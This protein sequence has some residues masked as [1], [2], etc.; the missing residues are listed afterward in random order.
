MAIGPRAT[1]QH[2][3]LNPFK[4]IWSEHQFQNRLLL[5]RKKAVLSEPAKPSPALGL[6]PCPAQ[7]HLQCALLSFT[8][9]PK[10]Q[11]YFGTGFIPLK[12]A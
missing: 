12:N 9:A 4:H 3:G 10:G 6:Q 7:E 11:H 1:S 8:I 5:V 2:F